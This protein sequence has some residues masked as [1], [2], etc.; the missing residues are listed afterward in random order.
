M[1]ERPVESALVRGTKARG[2]LAIKL[3]TRIGLPDRLLLLPG[4]RLLL[5]ECKRPK[6]RPRVSQE[7]MHE[8]LAA[9]GFEVELVDTHARV[10]E[11]LDA[12]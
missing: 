3:N 9:L 1:L 7:V 2:G 5:V 4:G 8:Q 11:V 12:L 10:K 6:G